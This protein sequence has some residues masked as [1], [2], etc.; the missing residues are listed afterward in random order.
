MNNN[1]NNNYNNSNN[2][3]NPKK[4]KANFFHCGLGVSKIKSPLMR[5]KKIHESARISS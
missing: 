1:C 4:F 2:N 3:I 5:N